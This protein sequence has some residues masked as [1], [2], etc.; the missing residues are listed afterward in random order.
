M[1]T[2]SDFELFCNR[3]LDGM[4]RVIAKLDDDQLNTE[5]GLPGANTVFQLVFHATQACT[6]WVDHIVCGSRTDRDRDAEFRSSG[7]AEEAHAAITELRKLLT[8]RSDMVATATELANTPR[9]VT[10]LGRPWTV[11]AALIHA[12]EELAQHLG[13]AEITADLVRAKS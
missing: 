9:T 7:T 13:H 12:Y 11:G 5:T 6:Y 8:A 10:P 1:I 4:G 2:V 3:T